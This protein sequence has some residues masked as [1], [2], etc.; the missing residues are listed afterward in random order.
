MLA[1]VVAADALVSRAG[2]P[3]TRSLVV[4]A[5]ALVSRAGAP[6][7]RSLVAAEVAG[8]LADAVAGKEDDLGGGAAGSEHWVGDLETWA[9]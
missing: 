8:A 4:T 3:R 9:W 1:L 5:D 2:A 7:A 6:R